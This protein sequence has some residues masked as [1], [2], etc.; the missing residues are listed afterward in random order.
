M[1]RTLASPLHQ[2][3]R[4]FLIRKRKEA[5]LTQAEVAKRLNRHQSYIANV[6][7]GQRRVDVVELVYLARALG[8]SPA[9]AVAAVAGSEGG[10]DIT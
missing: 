4:E 3:L 2:A 10:Q 9:E 5:G 6:E 1:S 7:G 8:F